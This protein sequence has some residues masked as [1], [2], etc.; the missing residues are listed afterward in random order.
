MP[1]LRAPQE[2]GNLYAKARVM[3]PERLSERE[4]QLLREWSKLR[5]AS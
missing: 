5:G 2:H 4:E 3:L 1:K